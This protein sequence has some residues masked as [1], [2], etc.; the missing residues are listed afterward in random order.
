LWIFGSVLVCVVRLS[1]ATFVHPRLNRSTKLDDIWRA[2]LW[3]QWHVVLD[4]VF[5][6]PGKDKI[7]GPTSCQNMQLKI[8]VSRM[9]LP[10][11][12]KRELG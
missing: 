6:P 7:W 4:G 3:V 2:H 5:G 1:S 11:D 9:L 10:V 12:Y 8:E